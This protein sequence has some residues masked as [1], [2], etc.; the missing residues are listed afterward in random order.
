M[1]PRPRALPG[2][3]VMQAAGASGVARTRELPRSHVLVEYTVKVYT[4]DTP[5][6]GTDGEVS[7]KP[8]SASGLLSMDTTR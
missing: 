3:H 1:R 2:I 8:D 5:G 7:S 4:S 6:A